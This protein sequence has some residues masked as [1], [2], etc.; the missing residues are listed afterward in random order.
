VRVNIAYP[1]EVEGHYSSGPYAW[2][3]QQLEGRLSA[4]VV[5]I[6]SQGT[7]VASHQRS[8][9]TGRPSTGAAH[10]P[11]AHQR[12]AAWPPPRLVLWAA[13]TGEAPA[14]VV[15][16]MLTSRPHPQ[17]G[18]RACLGIRRLGK[19]DGDERLEAA[20]RRAIRIGACS[21]KRS[22]AMLQ[23]DLDQQPWPGPPAAA[24]VITHGHI[25]GAPYYPS[26]A[27]APP[28]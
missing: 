1:V 7:R 19:S 25:R 13:K 21:Y 16:A 2:G 27:G 26:T 3:K 6:F 8:P 9:L 24:P 10:M 22:A 14:P 15:E 18:F 23:H 5:A 17:Q 12:Y 4:Q 11:T 28:G 20:C